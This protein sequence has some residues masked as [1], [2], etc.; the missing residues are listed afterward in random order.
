MMAL[1]GS[2]VLLWKRVWEEKYEKGEWELGVELGG[3]W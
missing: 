1:I 3:G 2:C